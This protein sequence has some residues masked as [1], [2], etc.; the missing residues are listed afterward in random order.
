MP[1]S[2]VEGAY[3][4]ILRRNSVAIAEVTDI[5]PPGLTRDTYEVSHHTSPNRWKEFRKGLKDG[6]EVTFTINYLP[7][8]S[9]HNAS[10]GV[11]SDFADDVTVS[12]WDIVFP[13]TG[14]PVWSFPGIV[15]AFTPLAPRAEGMRADVTLKVAGQPSFT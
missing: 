1:A 5:S 4:V 8:N 15:T 10:T 2:V 7:A 14:S 6:G 12:T 11:L 3:G 9:T 13:T